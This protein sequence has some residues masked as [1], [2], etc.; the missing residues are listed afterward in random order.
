[1]HVVS[2]FT[3][4]FFWPSPLE[5]TGEGDDLVFLPAT[6]G[7]LA[8]FAGLHTPAVHAD[9][10]QFRLV[11]LARRQLAM[12]EQL[13]LLVPLFH[14]RLAQRLSPALDLLA[15]QVGSPIDVQ[16]PGTIIK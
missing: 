16:R 10:Q 2:S 1:M 4:G 15:I 13:Q 3:G 14:Q 8:L 6:A 12:L 9:H 7:F 11:L 5:A